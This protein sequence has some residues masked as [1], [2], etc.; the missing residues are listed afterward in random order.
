MRRLRKQYGWSVNSLAKRYSI[1]VDQV[2]AIL[3]EHRNAL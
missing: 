3:G 2:K 1:D